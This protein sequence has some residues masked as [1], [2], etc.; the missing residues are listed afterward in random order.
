MPRSTL[1]SRTNTKRSMGTYRTSCRWKTRTLPRRIQ[2]GSLGRSLSSTSPKQ[3]L[4]KQWLRLAAVSNGKV[5][6]RDYLLEGVLLSRRQA[7][8]RVVNRAPVR[9]KGGL[10]GETQIPGPHTRMVK[11]TQTGLLAA[12]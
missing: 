12:E 9:A 4:A 8:P 6:A 2:T 10:L 3:S 11:M 5:K 7:P 1:W